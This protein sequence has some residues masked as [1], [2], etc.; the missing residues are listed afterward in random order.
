MLA[1][2]RRVRVEQADKLKRGERVVK[3][4]YGVD[5]ELCTGD[6]SCIRL[7]GC[8]S[9]TVKP[10]P[11]PLRR[12]PVATVVEN[13][14]GCGLCGEVAHAAVLCPSFYRADI[15]TNP[16]WWDRTLA[17][18]RSR[19][20]GELAN[21]S[22]PSPQRR[23]GGV[24]GL[25]TVGEPRSPSPKP[26]APRGEGE[27]SNAPHVPAQAPRPITILIAA[28]GGEG[29]GVLTDWIVTAAASQGFPVQ[30]TSIPG[31]AQRTGATTYHI[32]MVPAPMSGSGNGSARRP[33]LAL[34]PAVGDV[35]LLVASELMEAGRAVAGGYTAPDHERWPLRPA[36]LDRGGTEKFAPGAAPRFDPRRG[37]ASS[38]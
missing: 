15:V 36:A 18:I 13:C 21:Q 25:E 4:R 12:D 28:L 7:S 19:V 17:A 20:I 5:D 31:V 29:G 33:V 11:D 3:T 6:R 16:N 30:S 26:S 8:P 34:A 10:N 38:G 1:R 35:D 32:E 23:E 14:V 9:L 2:Q 37:C 24:R 22:S 27:S